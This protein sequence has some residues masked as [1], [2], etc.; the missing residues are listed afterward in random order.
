MFPPLRQ[1][2]KWQELASSSQL[3]EGTQWCRWLLWYS[4]PLTY[5]KLAS[6]FRQYLCFIF[7]LETVAILNV[8][9][10][11]VWFATD[12][13]I[14]KITKYKVD[15]FSPFSE[16]SLCKGNN[17]MSHMLSGTSHLSFLE[18][19]WEA[20]E[21]QWNLGAPRKQGLGLHRL[22]RRHPHLTGLDKV[23]ILNR[24]K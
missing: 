1:N 22:G 7:H 20:L 10:Y 23:W 15:F 18:R 4:H 19:W 11:S 8:D 24:L 12:V 14:I 5:S 2:V 21:A 13:D 6:G 16:V 3:A 9:L 17:L